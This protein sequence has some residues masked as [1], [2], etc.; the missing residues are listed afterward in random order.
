MVRKQA[1]P[2]TRTG[3]VNVGYFDDKVD[4]LKDDLINTF[5]DALKAHAETEAEAIAGIWRGIHWRDAVFIGSVGLISLVLSIATGIITLSGCTPPPSPSQLTAIAN[6]GTYQAEASESAQ[7]RTIEPEPTHTATPPAT[8]TPTPTPRPQNGLP[9]GELSDKALLQMYYA[10]SPSRLYGYLT[11]YGTKD[12]AVGVLLWQLG[13]FTSQL[14]RGAPLL[15]GGYGIETPTPAPVIEL[16]PSQV[17]LFNLARMVEGL[18]P[19]EARALLAG[20][21]DYV[22]ALKSPNDIGRVY[23]VYRSRGDRALLARVIVGDT[24]AL[25]DYT[26]IGGTDGIPLGWRVTEDP[27]GHLVH[28]LADVPD[29]LFDRLKRGDN[30]WAELVEDVYGEGCEDSPELQERR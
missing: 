6:N 4:A 11:L 8:P 15:G 28:W 23:C 3:I 1:A 14:E 7:V 10:P 21:Y 24:S 30:A 18:E 19:D 29:E 9:S 25:N 22:I 17:R 16:N 12:K 2:D 27:D 13:H 5:K 20:R 26:G